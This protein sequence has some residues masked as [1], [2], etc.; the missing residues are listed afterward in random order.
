M[1]MLPS[2]FHFLMAS[3][4]QV[5]VEVTA[6]GA[7]N[8]VWPAMGTAL[9]LDLNSY[10]RWRTQV[11]TYRCPS[12]PEEPSGGVAVINYGYCIVTYCLPTMP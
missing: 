11:S 5:P 9:H 6:I 12:D 2:F 3:T 10:T 7:F 4:M 1:S 8:G